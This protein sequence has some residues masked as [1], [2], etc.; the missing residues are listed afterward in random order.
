[1]RWEITGQ[2]G[3]HREVSLGTQMKG[4]EHF[5][6]TEHKGEQGVTGSTNPFLTKDP[7]VTQ[8][9]ERKQASLRVQNLLGDT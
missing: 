7:N 8:D 1:M 9:A 6:G 4:S 3:S 2:P 5:K